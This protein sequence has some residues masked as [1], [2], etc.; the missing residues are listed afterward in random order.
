MTKINTFLKEKYNLHENSS[1]LQNTKR[2]T[3]KFK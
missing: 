1:E 2:R 3:E